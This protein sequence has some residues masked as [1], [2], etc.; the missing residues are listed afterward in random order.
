MRYLFNVISLWIARKIDGR[1]LLFALLHR[2]SAVAG[3]LGAYHVDP[4]DPNLPP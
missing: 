2:P 3:R 4:F 1:T